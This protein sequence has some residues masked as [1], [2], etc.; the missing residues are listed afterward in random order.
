MHGS[1]LLLGALVALAALGGCDSASDPQPLEARPPEVSAFAFSPDSVFFDDAAVS[2]DTAVVDLVL[3]V[4]AMD[5]DGEIAR[6]RYAVRWQYAPSNERSVTGTLERGEGDRYAGTVELALPRDRRGLYNVLVYAV[7][8]DGLVSNQVSGTFLLAGP[9]LGPPVIEEVSA[10]AEFRP[11][12]TL[13]I[14]AAVSDPDGE[15]DIA[16]VEGKFPNSGVFQ[17]RDDGGGGSGDA[18]EGDGRYTV[19]FGI[20][21]ATPGPLPVSLWATDRDGAVSDTTRFTITIVE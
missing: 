5:P 11:P 17:L 2:G 9:G 12:G 19:T 16:R 15:D 1:R 13:K 3:S 14:V 20:D 4:L 6:V 8:D 18:T 7:D 10:P 21:A